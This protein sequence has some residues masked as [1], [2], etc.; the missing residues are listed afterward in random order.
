MAGAHRGLQRRRLHKDVEFGLTLCGSHVG[1]QRGCY[2]LEEVVVGLDEVGVFVVESRRLYAELCSIVFDRLDQHQHVQCAVD[3]ARIECE[4][5]DDD[6]VADGEA[7]DRID[8]IDGDVGT[9]DRCRD[10]AVTGT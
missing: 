3:L 7:Q 9:F 1:Y 10:A 6:L 8:V 5:L 4:V 2:A